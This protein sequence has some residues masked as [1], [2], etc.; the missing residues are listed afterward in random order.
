MA[1]V[2]NV[3]CPVLVRGGTGLN[4]ALILFALLGGLLAFGFIVGPL[5]LALFLSVANI[6]RRERAEV[7]PGNFT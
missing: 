4:G 1:L 2:D 7:D 6:R 3:I 5:A